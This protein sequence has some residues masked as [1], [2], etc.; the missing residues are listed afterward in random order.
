MSG[1]LNL[2]QPAPYSLEEEAYDEIVERCSRE[3]MQVLVEHSRYTDP[4]MC[5]IKSYVRPFAYITKIEGNIRWRNPSLS[6]H[7]IQVSGSSIATVIPAKVEA[8]ISI[9]TGQL[10]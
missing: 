10:P 8:K 7:K 3:S 5:L 4:K 6:I 1:V 9:R 2:S